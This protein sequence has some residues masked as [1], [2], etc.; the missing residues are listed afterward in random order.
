MP[1]TINDKKVWNTDC[2]RNMF[3]DNSLKDDIET[4]INAAN[5]SENRERTPATR[6]LTFAGIVVISSVF[7][8]EKKV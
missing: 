8:M 6:H 5:L 3:F 4:H 7:K 2:T 1:S